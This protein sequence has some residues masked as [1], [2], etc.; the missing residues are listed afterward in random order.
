MWPVTKDYSEYREPVVPAE[1]I[2]YTCGHDDYE[3]YLRSGFEVASMFNLAL[4]KNFGRVVGD[5]GDVLDFGCGSGRLSRFMNPPHL[6]GCDVNGPV[7]D[8]C[9]RTIPSGRFDQNGL[10]PPLPYTDESFDLVYSFSLFSHLRRD[11]EEVWL[12]ELV[13]VGAAQCVYLLSVQGD[14]MI[15]QTLAEEAEHARVAGF[16]FR[17]VHTRHGTALD[18]PDYYEASYHTA[19]WIYG[20]WNSHFDI[21]DVI[22]GDDPSRYLPPG[23]AFRP[24]GDVPHLRPMGQDLVIAIKR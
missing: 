17:N 14:W 23:T 16:Y 15:E 18:F 4:K 21:L 9:K 1:F 13:R 20:H 7:V 3:S 24:E 8:Y 22:S 11:I 10:L 6:F 12:R 2:R 5:Y 19:E